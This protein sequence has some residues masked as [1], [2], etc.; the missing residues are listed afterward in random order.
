MWQ[1]LPER[2]QNSASIKS[3]PQIG[4]LETATDRSVW[5]CINI[6]T[7]T[8]YLNNQSTILIT[9]WHALLTENIVHFCSVEEP[10]QSI[11]ERLRSR[12]RYILPDGAKGNQYYQTARIASWRITTSYF[13]FWSPFMPGAG[14]DLISRSRPKLVGAAKKGAD[15]IV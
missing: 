9:T 10:E 11:S 3:W 8:E 7:V 6:C 5:K 12:S 15:I 14:A 1:P 13:R 4:C 2:K